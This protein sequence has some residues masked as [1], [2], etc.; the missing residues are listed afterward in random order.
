LNRVADIDGFEKITRKINGGLNGY[1]D[2]LEHWER[3]KE[4]LNV[5]KPTDS[6][7]QLDELP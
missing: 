3:I 5:N 2:R 7:H 6:P 1:A 4:V